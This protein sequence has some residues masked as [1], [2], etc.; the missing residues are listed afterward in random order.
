MTEGKGYCARR[1]ENRGL[2]RLSELIE[3][4]DKIVVIPDY[5]KK[6]NAISKKS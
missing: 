2:K 1:Q 3:D 6:V 5:P 4:K